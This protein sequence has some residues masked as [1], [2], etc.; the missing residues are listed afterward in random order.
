MTDALVEIFG[1]ILG[2]LMYV[3]IIYGLTKISK[4]NLSFCEAGICVLL[5]QQEIMNNYKLE[6]IEKI[7]NTITRLV[8][9][10]L[11]TTK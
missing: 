10:L 4:F 1:L 8:K 11:E 7:N 6:K 9:A 5:F 2:T 3:A